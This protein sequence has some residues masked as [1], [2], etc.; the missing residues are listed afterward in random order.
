MGL[1]KSMAVDYADRNV[2][3]NAICPG[4]VDTPMLHWAVDR[5]KKQ[6]PGKDILKEWA[7]RHAQGRIGKAEEIAESVLFLASPR[8]SFITGAA[9]IVDGGRISML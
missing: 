2:R 3:V 5:L 7:G 4:T 6:N 1:T 9:L 8:A